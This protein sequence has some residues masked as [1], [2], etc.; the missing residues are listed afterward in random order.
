VTKLAASE[1]RKFLR[2][3]KR[4][5]E[6]VG[7]PRTRLAPVVSLEQQIAEM[8]GVLDRF[9]KKNPLLDRVVRDNYA[10]HCAAA[11]CWASD[12]SKLWPPKKIAQRAFEVAD[13]MMAERKKRSK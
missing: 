7:W 10:A 6:V 8:G 5:E 9:L 3:K 13:A 11:S 2:I 1:E 12:G 4:L